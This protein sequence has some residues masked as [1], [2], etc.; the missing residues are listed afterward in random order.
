MKRAVWVVS[1][2]ILGCC[3]RGK[4]AEGTN[5][6]A[7]PAPTADKSA[8]VAVVNG[9]TITEG[10]LE[11]TLGAKLADKQRE[12][13]ELKRQG[14]EEMIVRRLVAVEAKKN[15]LSENEYLKQQID[16][17]IIAPTEL[18]AKA[19]YEQNKDDIRQPFED[20]KDR[21]IGV[22]KQEREQQ[23]AMDVF[24]SLRDKAKIDVR[25]PEPVEPK[26]DVEA[27]GPSRGPENAAVTIVE[28]SDFQCPFCQKAATTVQKVLADYAGQVRLVYRQFPLEFHDKAFKAAEAGMCANEQGKF[29]EMH[30]QMF[31]DQKH[32]DVEGLKHAART[33][34]LDGA[35]FD[36]CIDK[37]QFADAVRKDMA[38]GQKAGVSGTPAFFING[39]MISGAQPYES[40][41]DAVDKELKRKTN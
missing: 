37:G 11:S 5:P 20:V 38:A 13:Y 14:L 41:R 40:F 26:I 30:D 29:W 34:G 17:K 2:F 33:I 24:K 4:V 32:L 16:P 8:V 12:L 3:T 9:E 25:L 21:V 36:D 39:R 28:F 19:F 18:E 27:I 6:A 23:V 15:N 35:K 10:D 7:A 22:L 1:I 31:G